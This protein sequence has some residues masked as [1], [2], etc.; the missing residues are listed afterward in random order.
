MLLGKKK[1]CR[2]SYINFQSCNLIIGAKWLFVMRPIKCSPAWR[3]LTY[4]STFECITA[5]NRSGW[6]KSSFMCYSDPISCVYKHIKCAVLKW[7][8]CNLGQ[9]HL[10]MTQNVAIIKTVCALR[11]RGSCCHW[12]APIRYHSMQQLTSRRH[13][14]KFIRK[15]YNAWIPVKG[16]PRRASCWPSIQELTPTRTGVRVQS[17]VKQV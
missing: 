3:W 9:H 8:R 6:C 16:V 2:T 13:K 12:N 7:T 15:Q 11:R 1:G 4:I 10:D 14:R 17:H 5:M